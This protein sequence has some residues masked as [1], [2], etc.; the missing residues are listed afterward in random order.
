MRSKELKTYNLPKDDPVIAQIDAKPNTLFFL[1]IMMGLLSFI[2]K[3]PTAYGVMIILVAL[4]AIIYMPRVILMEF[5]QEYL[6]LHNRAD[7]NNCVL[8]YYDEISSWYYSWSASRDYLYIEL[9]NGTTEKI[10]AFSKTIF[11]SNM[12]RFLRDKHRKNVK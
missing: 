8:I 3:L 5:Y 10:E 9:E 11:E 6:V 2:F 7:K 4:G 1:A 12:N